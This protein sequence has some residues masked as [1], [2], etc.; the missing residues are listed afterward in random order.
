MYFEAFKQFTTK[1][2]NTI[3][4]HNTAAPCEAKVLYNHRLNALEYALRGKRKGWAYYAPKTHLKYP[5]IK[6]QIESLCWCRQCF[7][8]ATEQNSFA[9]F[10]NMLWCHLVK[11]QNQRCPRWWSLMLMS[12]QKQLV[13]SWS[14]WCARNNT[15]HFRVVK[16]Y[17]KSNFPFVHL[18]DSS[19]LRKSK[20]TM[21]PFQFVDPSVQLLTQNETNPKKQNYRTNQRWQNMIGL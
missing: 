5:Q 12:S 10:N 4:Q 21:S 16:E 1:S 2:R 9:H 20:S 19:W 3:W 7:F 6:L 13:Q 17:T 15:L 8:R 14:P 11:E 18:D